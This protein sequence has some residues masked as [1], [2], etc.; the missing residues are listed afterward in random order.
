MTKLRDAMV[1]ASIPRVEPKVDRRRA[2]LPQP[3]FTHYK[4]S[5]AY[6]GKDYLF[7]GHSYDAEHESS[8]TAQQSKRE[9]AIAAMLK[10]CELDAK[11]LPIKNAIGEKNFHNVLSRFERD[12]L[13]RLPDT[14]LIGPA[15]DEKGKLIRESFTVWRKE[16]R[17]QQQDAPRAKPSEKAPAAKAAKKPATNS[18]S[19]ASK[20]KAPAK[21]ATP[22]AAIKPVKKTTKVAARGKK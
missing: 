12:W 15:I 10:N 19:K 6:P 5:K 11:W 2:S 9:K 4:K 22:K 18:S 21:K 13:H 1:A 17:K 16:M 14:V 7:V 20:A 3:D 8:D